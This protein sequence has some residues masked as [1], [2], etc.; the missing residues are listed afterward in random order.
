M[1]RE[2]LRVLGVLP[3]AHSADTASVVFNRALTDLELEALAN[4][5]RFYVNREKKEAA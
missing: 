1:P 3:D 4:L 2:P 5:L